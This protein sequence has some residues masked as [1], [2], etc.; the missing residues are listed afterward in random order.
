MVGVWRATQR[1]SLSGLSS[2]GTVQVKVS[3]VGDFDDGIA[4]NVCAE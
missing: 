4:A 1:S 3:L 2:S